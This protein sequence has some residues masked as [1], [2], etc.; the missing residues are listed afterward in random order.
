MSGA[1]IF[2]KN[3]FLAQFQIV[4]IFTIFVRSAPIELPSKIQFSKNCLKLWRNTSFVDWKKYFYQMIFS[5]QN[6]R[7]YKFLLFLLCPRLSNY[8]QKFN[9]LKFALNCGETLLL[10]SGTN[11]YAKK[12][13][14][15]HNLRQYKIF[16]N[17]VRSAPV[18]LPHK[19]QFSK[20]Y[21]KL[22]RTTSF[23]DWKK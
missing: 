5:Q 11:K 1:N 9:F 2:T 12:N 10:M 21:L 6:L 18:Q 19:I 14:A 8:R 20:N 4:Q 17:F 7:Q 3:N 13:F 16:T 15:Q 23:D 22:W